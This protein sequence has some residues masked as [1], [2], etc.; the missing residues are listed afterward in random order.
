M[1]SCFVKALTAIAPFCRECARLDV[2]CSSDPTG[3]AAP[4]LKRIAQLL[5][6]QHLEVQKAFAGLDQHR[7]GYLSPNQLVIQCCVAAPLP[8]CAVCGGCHR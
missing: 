8:F 5:T 7:K 1:H 2:Q 4:I 3:T 6:Q